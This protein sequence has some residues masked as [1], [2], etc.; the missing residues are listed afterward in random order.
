[1]SYENKSISRTEV[2][3]KCDEYGI[4]EHSIRYMALG[5]EI[6]ICTSDFQSDSFAAQTQIR[7]RHNIQFCTQR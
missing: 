2:L 5:D 1:M 3:G 7:V 4:T 6:E